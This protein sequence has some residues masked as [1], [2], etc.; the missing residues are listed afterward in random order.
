M[1]E[2][3]EQPTEKALR[4]AREKGQVAVSRDLARLLSLSLL[5]EL[6]FLA[7]APCR[8]ALQALFGLSIERINAPFAPARAE[9]AAQAFMLMLPVFGASLLAVLVAAIAGNWGQF[10]IL[11]APNVLEPNIDKLNP[12]NGV[13]NLFSMKKVV[14]VGIALLKVALIAFVTWILIRDALPVLVTFA[15]GTPAGIHGQ[16]LAL[17]HVMFRTLCGI[18]LVLALADFGVQRHFLIKQLM[19][20]KDDIKR[21][22]KDAEGDPQVKGQRRQLAQELA[23]TPAVESTEQADAVVVNPTHFA[24]ALRYDAATAQV[25]VMLAKGR[26][27]VAQAMI[28]RAHERGIPVIRHVWLARTLYATGAPARPV[29]RASYAAVAHVFAVIEQMEGRVGG[30]ALDLETTGLAPE[31]HGQ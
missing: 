12:V 9:L 13:K 8:E 25:P 4:D 2:K 11:I 14:E 5:G 22:H 21:E 28:R 1:S 15:G 19:M 10:G 17:V 3:S 24:I 18:C 7:E 26:D 6:A 23:S 31:A 30:S 20:S 29:P 16:F 27:E